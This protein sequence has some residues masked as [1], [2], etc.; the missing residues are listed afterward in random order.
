MQNLE[1]KDKIISY[2]D[3]ENKKN[4]DEIFELK[5]NYEKLNIEKLSLISDI[6]LNKLEIEK[7]KDDFSLNENLKAQINSLIFIIKEKDYAIS[8]LSNKILHLENKLFKKKDIIFELQ[9]II[10]DIK[11]VNKK[12]CEIL[13][14]IYY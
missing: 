1:N 5:N 7:F 14:R 9:R 8:D 12:C 2:L 6:K 10:L 4:Q 3:N 13:E 11:G